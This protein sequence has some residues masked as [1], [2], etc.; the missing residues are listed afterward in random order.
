MADTVEESREPR[1]P[2]TS[3]DNALKLILIVRDRRVLRLSEAA[4]ELGIAGSTAHRLLAML[5][6]RGFVRQDPATKI[7]VPGPELVGA[8]NAPWAELDLERRARPALEEL[9]ADVAETAHLCVLE[10]RETLFH[11]GIESSRLLRTGSR[12]G[13]HL[14]AHCTSGGKA[15]LAQLSDE[16]LLALYGEAPLETMTDRSISSLETLEEELRRV[17]RRGYA[18]NEGE[19]EP[20]IAAVAV[21]LDPVPDGPPLALAISAPKPRLSRPR[22]RA[23]VDALQH[24]SRRLR[25]EL[26]PLVATG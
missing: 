4:R 1:Y 18:T 2:L 14:P 21:A 9:V 3:V 23:A 5:R 13:L 15:M 24:A 10:G 26:E 12:V 17:R 16:E 19:S 11:T 6:H 25:S 7:Y 22:V 8:S 20:E